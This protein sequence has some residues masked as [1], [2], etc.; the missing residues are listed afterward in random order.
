LQRTWRRQ[1]MRSSGQVG[2]RKINRNATVTRVRVDDQSSK[3]VAMGMAKTT[4]CVAAGAPGCGVQGVSVGLG[5]DVVDAQWLRLRPH[6]GRSCT[7]RARTDSGM[8]TVPE[9]TRCRHSHANTN[10]GSC[11]V[12][13]SAAICAPTAGALAA[14][15][16][17][18][19]AA[20]TSAFGM[21]KN[22]F[23]VRRSS[24]GDVPPTHARRTRQITST[25]VG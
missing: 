4:P 13:A 18:S 6:C 23:Y 8:C 16:A 3:R 14:A 2:L 11:S 9:T 19:S 21:P 5:R 17:A 10:S 1:A 22:M 7:R 24:S 20:A 15:F 12:A 25:R